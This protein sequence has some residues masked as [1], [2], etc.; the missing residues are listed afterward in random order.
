MTQDYSA[1][2]GKEMRAQDVVSASALARWCATF[3]RAVPQTHA[4]QAYH[5]CL[6]LPDAPTAQLDADG[7]PQRGDF[8]PPVDLPRRM[9]AGSDVEFLA[10][11]PV[12]G[13]IE[14]LS[15]IVSVSEKS[16][17]S[18]RLIFVDVEH[19]TS[20]NGVACVREVQSLVYRAAATAPMAA[21]PAAA[22]PP[23]LAP[24]DWHKKL[25]PDARLLFRYSALTFNTHRI[26]YDLAYARDV[27]GYP[28]LVVHGP[29]TA[30]LLVEFCTQ[31]LGEQALRRFRFKGVSP[32]FAGDA[33]YLVGKRDG[34]ALALAALGAD[35]RTVMQAEAHC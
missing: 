3:D 20:A 9:W 10:P 21:P 27:E 31:H 2:I 30:S 26:H 35:G 22:S 13:E 25:Q 1:W 34:D 32:A 18:G 5:W 16:G 29:L 23:D 4:P 15:R 24:W 11:L 12:Q 6:C 33:L 14:R 8:L 19:I 28:A 7:H 17:S